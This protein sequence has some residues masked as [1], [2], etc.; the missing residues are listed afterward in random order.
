MD[1]KVAR[2]NVPRSVIKKLKIHDEQTLYMFATEFNNALQVSVYD[3]EPR[4]GSYSVAFPTS[5][6]IERMSIFSGKNE[7]FANA[8]AQIL[9]G[10]KN[11][12]VYASV[13]L[14]N[15]M[16]ITLDHLKNLIDLFIE[17]SQ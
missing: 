11:K 13:F 15:S 1:D 3:G 4:L 2:Q 9:A 7:S 12:I 8:V 6:S 5:D 17:N 16:A 14:N 10:R